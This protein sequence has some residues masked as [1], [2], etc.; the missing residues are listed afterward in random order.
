MKSII[1]LVF[2]FASSVCFAQDAKQSVVQDIA[3]E[4]YLDDISKLFNPAK[5]IQIEFKYEVTTPE[6]PSKVTDHGSIIIKGDKYKL[7][8]D[9]GEMY[10]NGKNLWVYNVAA[11]EVY[12]SVP[13]GENMDE[14]LMA[15]FRLIK[16][17]KKYYKYRLMD[18]VLLSGTNYVQLELYPIDLNTSYSIMRVLIDKKTR[19]LYSFAMQQKSGVV[20]TIFTKEIIKDV[21]ISE[22]AFSWNASLYKDVL[23]IEM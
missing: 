17:F 16:D 21:K 5:A 14:M 2:V 1:L 9:D 13:T 12:R 7:K 11:A 23:E 18:D 15:P 22:T 3:A 4:P 6:P 10:F 19:V 8:L 20:Y